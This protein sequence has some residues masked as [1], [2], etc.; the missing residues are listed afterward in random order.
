MDNGSIINAVILGITEGLTEFLPVSS[1]GHILL[2][3]HFLGFESTGFV[4]E[5]VIQ[6]GAILAI[7]LVYFARL[8]KL[9]VTLPSSARSRRFVAGIL[10]AFLPAAFIGVLAHGFIKTVLFDTPLVI[11]A[12]LI[13]GGILLLVIDKMPLKVRYT[14]IM[15]YPLSLCL[16][17]GIFQCLAMI[18]G[19]SRSGATI[20][21]SLL[22]GTDKR[23]AAEF[24]FFLAMPTMFGAVVYDLYKNRDY[25]SSD[26][27]G[28][29][30]VG[31]VCAFVAALI[32]VRSL[33][34]FVTRHGFAPFA[35]WRIGVGVLGIGLIFALSPEGAMTEQPRA[36]MS[37]AV[38]GSA[39]SASA[40]PVTTGKTD[41]PHP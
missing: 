1:T 15:D 7:L 38:T 34:D 10:L 39:S 14:D 20:A 12:A 32:V 18:P 27:L 17:I 40:A 4:F 11:C 41:R 6:L 35:W 26:D 29:M 21:G 9:F 31:F 16:K 28:L 2:L 37:G 8:W 36:S 23:S 3:G 19:T 24:S 13:V 33:L 22:M 30:A 5:I 25:L